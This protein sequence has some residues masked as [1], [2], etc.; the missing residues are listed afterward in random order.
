MLNCL[1]VS[2]VFYAAMSGPAML[3]NIQLQHSRQVPRLAAYLTDRPERA[4]HIR[5]L[6]FQHDI[7]NCVPSDA[8]FSDLARWSHDFASIPLILQM[9]RQLTVLYNVPLLTTSF[10]T[11]L[12]LIKN[13]PNLHSISA[14][15][16]EI[17]EIDD[18]N[19]F[20]N[21]DLDEVSVLCRSMSSVRNLYLVDY[22]LEDYA[23]L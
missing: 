20:E 21:S 2:K 10:S 22:P 3:D 7:V 17:Y 12:S 15:E 11:I 1:Q 18:V 6:Q 5:V 23:P 14:L 16:R 19:L 8:G 9:T 4:R 13:L